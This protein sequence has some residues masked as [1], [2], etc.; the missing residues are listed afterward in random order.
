MPVIE[1]V[2]WSNLDPQLRDLIDRGRSN[3]MLSTTIPPQIWAYRP[4][5]AKEQLRLYEE[6]FQRGV[7]DE[8]L[9]ELVRLRIASI[10]DCDACKLARKSDRVSEQEISCL[11][12]DDAS[13]SRVERAALRFA[14]LFATEHTALDDDVFA[15][16]AQHFSNEQIVELGMFAAL[17]LGQ[18]RLAY[19]LR[20]YG[21]DDRPTLLAHDR[22]PTGG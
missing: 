6:F 10:N 2:P 16:L 21:Q 4:G 8:R 12:A 19:V 11:S 1:P 3:G 17:M 5:P 9:M 14:E 7:L 15:E 13:F 22:Q 20:A 18:G